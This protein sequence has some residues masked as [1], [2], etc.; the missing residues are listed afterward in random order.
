MFFDVITDMIF[1]ICCFGSVTEHASTQKQRIEVFWNEKRIEEEGTDL[2]K[3]FNKGRQTDHLTKSVNYSSSLRVL[4]N[5]AFPCSQRFLD[6][7]RFHIKQKWIR[8]SRAAGLAINTAQMH[9][10]CIENINEM[11]RAVLG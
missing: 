2:E 7:N 3:Q 11:M 10:K 1:I 5:F 9:I 4:S 6:L 8:E